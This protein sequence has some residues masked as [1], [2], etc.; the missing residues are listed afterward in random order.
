MGD[1]SSL[2]NPNSVSSLASLLLAI[3]VSSFAPLYAKTISLRTNDYLLQ[4]SA[5]VAHV[6]VAGVVEFGQ[7]TVQVVEIL[8]S[9]RGPAQGQLVLVA[10][11]REEYDGAWKQKEIGEEVI[12]FAQWNDQSL[13]EPVR[14]RQSVVPLDDDGSIADRASLQSLLPP[15]VAPTAKS[16]LNYLRDHCARDRLEVSVRLNR[17]D[18]AN[19]ERDR[20]L[21]LLVEIKNAGEG[22][23]RFQNHIEYEYVHNALVDLERLQKMQDEMAVPHVKIRVQRADQLRELHAL[24]EMVRLESIRV[25]LNPGETAVGSYDLGEEYDIR[26]GGSFWVWA[27]VGGQSSPRVLLDV[28]RTGEEI[29]M[30]K[31]L[32]ELARDDGPFRV[33]R[34]T[35][36][37]R[38][39]M[40]PVES[41]VEAAVVEATL[42]HWFSD[43]QLG[44]PHHEDGQN[45]E[46]V[47]VLRGSSSFTR[48]MPRING[49]RFLTT[50]AVWR[51][52]GAPTELTTSS[53]PATFRWRTVRIKSV[54]V[55]GADATVEIV[56]YDRHNLGG[57][58]KLQLRRRGATWQVSEKILLQQL[59]RSTH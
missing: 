36:P 16:V 57:G 49:V 21:R 53:G 45:K 31:K 56:Q 51:N 11:D 23:V 28:P 47:I 58:A 44:K 30:L 41:I 22:E 40:P 37:V 38:R 18:I 50:E 17:E 39:A 34:A 52:D 5:L 9:A 8:D 12:L 7:R 59:L 2:T 20:P 48:T 29:E 6:R 26:S 54:H 35:R 13:Y 32:K 33:E 55:Q 4:Q 19:Y 43:L 14:M 1:R 27:E 42:K 46:E 3:A 24:E 15:S 10:C 25:V